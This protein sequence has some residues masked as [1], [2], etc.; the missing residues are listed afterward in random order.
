MKRTG[1]LRTAELLVDG[2]RDQM[3]EK[4]E[5]ADTW[6]DREV[7][8]CGVM[9]E[10]YDCC[11]DPVDYCGSHECC[12]WPEPPPERAILQDL[13]AE[14]RELHYRVTPTQL[15]RGE[16][17]ALSI[18]VCRTCRHDWPCATARI[19]DRYDRSSE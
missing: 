1:I 9:H 19:L 18:K 6:F 4:R 8:S 15:S 7:C 14:L 13:I 5:G 3:S 12:P 2:D 16:P 10:R 17:Y 11:G